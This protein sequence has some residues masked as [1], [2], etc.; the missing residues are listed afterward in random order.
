MNGLLS[1]FSAIAAKEFLHMKRDPATIIIALFIPMLQLVLLGYAL[2]FDVKH[3]RTAVVDMSKTS[4]SRT[5]IQGLVNTQYLDVVSY[6]P[7][8]DQAELALRRA[9]VSVAVIIPPDFDR[10]FG[11]AQPPTVQVYIDG[12]DGQVARPALTAFAGPPGA[13]Q[14]GGV[15]ARYSVLYNPQIRTQVYTIPALVCVLLQLI[16]VSLTSFSLVRERE[17]G[18]LDQLMVSPVGRLGLTLGKLAPYSVLAM[19]ELFVVLALGCTIFDI[20]IAGSTLLLAL[21]AVPFIMASLSVGL[22]I[23]TIAQ[24]QAQALQ[25]TM[26]TVMPSILLSGYIS[27]RDTLPGALYLLSDFIPVTHFIAISRGIVVRGAGF[28]DLLPSAL[29]LCGLSVV[30]ISAAT[31]RF[32]KSGA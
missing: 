26:L 29:W 5:Y 4:E 24:N 12:S 22:L 14:N 18:T 11:T 20:S 27:P 31:L 21:F 13:A 6:L 9:E 3:V 23:S 10:R 1:G 16:T 7:T 32:R 8:P 28:M 19:I 2:N 30:L 25:L 17:Q 15:Q